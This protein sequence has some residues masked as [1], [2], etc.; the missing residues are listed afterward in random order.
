MAGCRPL[1]H[2]CHCWPWAGLPARSSPERQHIY[3][4]RDY[5]IVQNRSRA[6]AICG[7]LDAY[8]RRPSGGNRTLGNVLET[9]GFL[10]DHSAG[11]HGSGVGA[12]RTWRFLGR[13]ATIWMEAR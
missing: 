8:C 3:Q 13:C 10:R 1:V 5:R 12:D 2:T 9:W 11:Q 6:I 7:P 4:A